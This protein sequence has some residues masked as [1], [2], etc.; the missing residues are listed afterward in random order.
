MPDFAEELTRACSD[1]FDV[2]FESA[3]GQVWDTVLPLLNMY[4]R[5]PVCGLLSQY[6]VRAHGF[7]DTDRFLHMMAQILGKCLIPRGF[8]Q[9]EF[10]EEQL[11]D[12]LREA[13]QWIAEGRLRYLDHVLQRPE[14]APEALIGFPKGQNFGKML[15]Q[16]G[17]P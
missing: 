10:S 7:G 17:E 5:V 13:G 3:G 14:Q 11:S 4:A 12:P 2:H 8:I 6:Q 9:T 1:G 16:I 15:V